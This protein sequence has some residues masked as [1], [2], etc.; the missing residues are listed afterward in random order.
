MQTENVD[1]S[2][3][4]GPRRTFAQRL[5]RAMLVDST[6]YE[7]VEH[8]PAALPQAAVVV[9]LAAIA[10]ALGGFAE[11][12]FV[13]GMVQAFVLWGLGTATVWLIGVRFLEHTSDFPELARTLGYALAPQLLFAIGLLPLGP[14][15][16]PLALAV[17]VLSIVAWVISVRQALDI[18]TL[19]SFGICVVAY[20]ISAIAV[21]ILPLG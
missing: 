14:L 4:S 19:R 12:G 7:E 9:G 6:V 18:G 15:V 5:G 21:A 20:L 8:D 13:R 2:D 11:V 10:G 16:L 1:Y 17:T 3:G